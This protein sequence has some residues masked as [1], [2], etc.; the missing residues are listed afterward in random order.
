M[1]SE[2]L[3][4]YRSD[5]DERPITVGA[6]TCC[7]LEMDSHEMLH[8]C[9]C[10]DHAH[11]GSS[12]R[13]TNELYFC[14]IVKCI[15]TS[16][17]IGQFCGDEDSNSGYRPKAPRI[18]LFLQKSLSISLGHRTINY[19]ICHLST[20]SY[21]LC[22]AGFAKILFSSLPWSH[23]MTCPPSPKAWAP[24]MDWWDPRSL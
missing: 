3:F 21:N 16:W 13:S 24:I 23:F 12:I 5:C 14:L 15:T 7:E 4:L 11:I 8:L 6:V 18:K 2:I 17:R 9:A 22:R 1:S 20:D 19:P 10:N